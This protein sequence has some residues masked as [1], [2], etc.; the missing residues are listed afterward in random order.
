MTPCRILLAAGLLVALAAPASAHRPGEGYIFVHRDE[1]ALG[2]RVEFQVDDLEQIVTLDRDA[3]GVVTNAELDAAYADIEA[4]VRQRIAL[5]TATG[6]FDLSFVAHDLEDHPVG[7]F[8]RLHFEVPGLTTP[9]DLLE[10]EYRALFDVIPDHRGFLVVE[11]NVLVGLEENES[12]PSLIFAPDSA[13]QETDLTTR[14]TTEGFL[15]FVRHGIWHIWIGLDHILF[16]LSLVMVSVLRR[17]GNGWTSVGGFVPALINVAKVVTLFTVAHSITLSLA[18]LGL[19]SLSPRLV[20]SIIALSVVAAALNN[21]RPMF[22]DW[23]WPVVFGFGLFHGFGFAT[24]LEPLTL[25]QTALVLTL[26]GFNLGVEIGQL[27]VIA[28]TFPI[29][30]AIRMSTAYTRLLL[31]AGSAAIALVALFWFVQRAFEIG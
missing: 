24:V 12:I 23:T 4:Y 1:A 22:G 30:F 9:P 28:V 27:A 7:R 16:V 25:N 29:L 2:G 20:E 11:R 14:P 19:V 31:P 26:F 8:V 5:G 6:D 13:R 15:A 3:D 18:S 21:I 10:V 17:S